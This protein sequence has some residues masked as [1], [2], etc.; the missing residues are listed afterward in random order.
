VV[1]LVNRNLFTFRQ[2]LHRFAELLGDLSQNH[3]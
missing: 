2:S 1:E 3:R